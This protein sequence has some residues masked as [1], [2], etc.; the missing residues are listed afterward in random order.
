MEAY[1]YT[2]TVHAH[3]DSIRRVVEGDV[4]VFP[5]ELKSVVLADQRAAVEAMVGHLP[6]ISGGWTEWYVVPVANA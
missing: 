3:D 6:H 5:G 1:A 4:Q 2:L